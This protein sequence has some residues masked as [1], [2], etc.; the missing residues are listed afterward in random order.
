M[1]VFEQFLAYST[2]GKFCQIVKFK[3][4]RFFEIFAKLNL[5]KFFQKTSKSNN[6][7]CLSILE[8]L[9]AWANMILSQS[10]KN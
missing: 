1:L 5:S 4:S 9:T 7:D 6:I 3:E 2:M 8:T 10:F